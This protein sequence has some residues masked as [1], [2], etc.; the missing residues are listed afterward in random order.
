MKKNTTIEDMQKEIAALKEQAA[1]KKDKSGKD[2][3]VCP[4]CGGDLEF[5]EDGVVYCSHC[6][7]YYDIE[8]EED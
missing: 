8:E 4:D 2:E 6:K 5:V 3:D 7:Q 1:A